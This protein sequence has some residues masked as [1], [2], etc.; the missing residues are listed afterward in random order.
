M[1]WHGIHQLKQI[2]QSRLS[3]PGS[4]MRVAGCFAIVSFSV[5]ALASICPVTF[6]QA[7]QAEAVTAATTTDTTVFVQPAVAV[8]LQSRIDIGIIPRSGG[9]FKSET[10]EL[11][12]S[13]NNTTGYG[14]YLKT[15][16]DDNSLHN[17]VAPEQVIAPVTADS[18]ANDFSKN[19]W[20][21]HLGTTPADADTVYSAVPTAEGAALASSDQTATKD[22][23]QLTFGT[24]VDIDLPAGE[25]TNSVLVSVVAN[26]M[27]ITSLTQLT[28]MQDMTA[29]ICNI[30]AENATTQLI[31]T[32]DG[33]K[34]WVAKLKD[35][36][37]W[38]TQNLALELGRNA[39]GQVTAKNSGVVL[40]AN[41]SDI[42][43]TTNFTLS[44]ET[45]DDINANTSGSDVGRSF[46]FPK[47]VLNSLVTDKTN[48]VGL[49]NEIY[50]TNVSDPE[51]RD[52]YVA[53]D[54]KAVEENS[55]TYDAHYLLGVFYQHSAITAGTVN[56]LQSICPKGWQL[57]R[58]GT[59]VSTSSFASLLPLYGFST[60]PT[61]ADKSIVQPPLYLG[62][63]GYILGSAYGSAETY[64]WTA[65]YSQPTTS[66]MVG[67]NFAQQVIEARS[68]AANY[69]GFNVRCIAK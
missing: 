37:C 28:Y 49:N 1:R 6:G 55:K 61:E 13:T 2:Y 59:N 42:E 54:T 38:M 7:A 3:G 33:N 44:Y 31:D 12:V 23:Y 65:G 5:I 58:N 43:P 60:K 34:Y 15:T 20:G 35:G 50:Y 52:T 11:T 18:A 68:T 46:Y 40:N 16:G 26:P 17:T 62:S 25:Y 66:Y 45:T 22:V 47:Y 9:V 19:T 51:W 32:R 29:D 8:S 36:K 69:H 24:N 67:I 48:N 30:S 64:Y 27:E 10:A 21:Y 41:N 39:D 63:F 4:W 57:W 53:T 14:L 56:G